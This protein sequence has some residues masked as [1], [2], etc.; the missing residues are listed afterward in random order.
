MGRARFD[1]TE[2]V[3]Q[4]DREWVAN[5]GQERLVNTNGASEGGK[6]L[7][8]TVAPDWGGSQ[9]GKEGDT[10]AYDADVARNRA[11]GAESMNRAPVAL[12]QSQANESR[13]LQMGALGM[14]RAQAEGS[15]PSS[16]QIL[17][18]RAN[19]NAA[20]AASR[21]AASGRTA[22][23]GLSA[24]NQA[25]P[26]AAN[27]ALAANTA[28]ANAR[29]GEIAHAQDVYASGAQHVQNQDIGAATTNAQLVAQQRALNEARQRGFERRGWNVRNTESQAEDR[30]HRNT[31]DALNQN[32]ANNLAQQARNSAND[33]EQ[34]NM[35]LSGLQAAFG[36]A[37]MSDERSKEDVRPLHM[38][39]LSHLMRRCG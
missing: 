10:S 18:Q 17:S 2:Q 32:E 21:A 19:Q 31:Q 7:P 38:G 20:F 13:G 12:D 34:M 36:G 30:Y 39:S 15:A 28:N 26:M 27:Q 33:R 16:A 22:A 14:L 5:G 9:Y 1:N 3:A 37:S 6:L 29:A 11:M 23:G 4:R 35:Y 8:G 25:S 24:F